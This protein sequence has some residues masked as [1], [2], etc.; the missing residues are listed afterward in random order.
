MMF[1]IV[2]PHTHDRCH[3]IRQH[4]VSAKIAKPRN[5]AKQFNLFYNDV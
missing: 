4:I 1:V 5:I 3:S 2:F